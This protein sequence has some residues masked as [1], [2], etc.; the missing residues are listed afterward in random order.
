M[1]NVIWGIQLATG[2]NNWNDGKWQEQLQNLGKPSAT[3]QTA[4]LDALNKKSRRVFE[5]G[6]PAHWM[7]IRNQTFVMQRCQQYSLWDSQFEFS[8]FAS[9]MLHVILNRCLCL[10]V[11]AVT[12]YRLKLSAL[13]HRRQ[14]QFDVRWQTTGA[15]TSA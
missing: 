4:S 1:R 3:N 10:F 13:W 8:F 15:L 5:G 14:I 2:D 12:A 11:C 9:G 6:C 7:Y